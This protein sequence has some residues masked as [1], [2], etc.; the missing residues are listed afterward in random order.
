VS[1]KSFWCNTCGAHYPENWEF[2][3]SLDIGEVFS[4]LQDCLPY[5][6]ELEDEGPSGSGWQYDKLVEL[7]R[8]IETIYA[9]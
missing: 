3:N 2:E 1:S 7:I 4:I 6:S 9:Q 8:K 5:L